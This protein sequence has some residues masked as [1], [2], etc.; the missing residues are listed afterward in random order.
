MYCLQISN[1]QLSRWHPL[2][3]CPFCRGISSKVCQKFHLGHQMNPWFHDN[4]TI[5]WALFDSNTITRVCLDRRTIVMTTRITPITY[6]Q[7]TPKTSQGCKNNIISVD[8]PPE[9]LAPGA[10]SPSK[11]LMPPTSYLTAVMV[12]L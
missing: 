8:M 4:N 2:N 1:H 3:N 5:M 12:S 11:L 10:D 9:L 6:I 7:G